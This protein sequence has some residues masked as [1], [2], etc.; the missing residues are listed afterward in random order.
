MT[1]AATRQA[2]VCCRMIEAKGFR[3]SL[4]GKSVPCAFIEPSDELRAAWTWRS[5]LTASLALASSAFGASAG[6]EYLPKLPSAGASSSGSEYGA[7]KTALRPGFSKD[8]SRTGS[9]TLPTAVAESGQAASGQAA[10]EQA[11]KRR[12]SSGRVEAARGRGARL[13]PEWQAEATA[14]AA[15]C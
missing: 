6:E 14:R 13:G 3:H 7:D 5:A 10:R 15:S 2:P 11:A 12:R 8:A 4:A 1:A 9:D